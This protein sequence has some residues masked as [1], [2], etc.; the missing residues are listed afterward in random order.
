[1]QRLE[2]SHRFV[3]RAMQSGARHYAVL[4]AEYGR[5]FAG[6]RGNMAAAMFAGVVQD[7]IEW[8]FVTRAE[9]SPEL[10]LTEAGERAAVS[11]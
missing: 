4:Q 9:G 10:S 8:K 7:L 2:A 5:H 11:H 6:G 1:M 3:I